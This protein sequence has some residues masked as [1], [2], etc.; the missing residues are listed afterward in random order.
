MVNTY[1][2]YWKNEPCFVYYKEMKDAYFLLFGKNGQLGWELNRTLPTLGEL[3]ILDYPDIDL[4][5]RTDEA[6]GSILASSTIN[7]NLQELMARLR[8]ALGSNRANLC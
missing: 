8:Y 5:P 7:N 4:I 2:G 3:K 1:F 6:V